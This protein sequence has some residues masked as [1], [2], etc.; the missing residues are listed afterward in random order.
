MG[1][2][3][4]P[5]YKTHTRF[6]KIVAIF[7]LAVAAYYSAPVLSVLKLLWGIFLGTHI[8]TSDL[9]C[10]KSV[11]FQRWGIFNFI[12]KPFAKAGHREILH[13]NFWGPFIL[14][15]FTYCLCW[16]AGYTLEYFTGFGGFMLWPESVAGMVIAIEC[17]ILIDKK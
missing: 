14:I 3:K 1:R 4:V 6:N 13:N 17:H 10:F 7:L 2:E 12:W 15:S 16:I 8:I 11:V 5:L 9:D